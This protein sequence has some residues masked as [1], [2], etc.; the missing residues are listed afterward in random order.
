MHTRFA[1]RWT[2]AAVERHSAG[3]LQIGA[4][5]GTLAGPV[6]LEN[7]TIKTAAFDAH[8][9]HL[10]VNWLPLALLANRLAITRL[11]ATQV[12]LVVHRTGNDKPFRLTRPVVPHLP[13]IVAIGNIDV[14]DMKVFAPAL[15]QPV[16]ITQ[17]NTTLH[18][19][20][21][22]W[23][24]PAL[25]LKGPYI[26]ASGHGKWKFRNGEQ[27]DSSL[28]WNLN[29]PGQVPVGGRASLTGDEQQMAID[30]RLRK[31]ARA[32]LAAEVHRPFGNNPDW[33]G[34]LALTQLNARD[35]A[36]GLPEMA[37]TGSA[38]FSGTPDATNFAGDVYAH[39]PNSGEWHGKFAARYRTGSVDIHQLDLVR[40]NTPTQF[41]LAG[42]IGFVD[43]MPVPDLHGKWQAL[44]LP[45]T[46]RPWFE[47]PRGTL[48]VQAHNE[49]LVVNLSGDLSRGGTINAQGELK[50]RSPERKWNL[51]AAARNFRLSPAEIRAAVPAFNWTLHA[52]GD[53]Q[54]TRIDDLA[55]KGFGG[56]VN[57]NG[58]YAH[59]GMHR[60]HATVTARHLDPGLLF[61]EYPGRINLIAELSG[62]R[63]PSLTCAVL[64]KSLQG[65]LRNAPV[66]ATG[67][68][69]CSSGKW[70]FRNVNIRV[71]GNQLRFDGHLRRK[72][73]INWNL[74]A[75]ELSAVWPGLSGSLTSR[76][77][78]ELAGKTPLARFSLHAADLRYGDY[79]VGAAD[80]NVAMN[81]ATQGGDA[82]LEA[83]YMTF[84]GADISDLTVRAHGSLAAHSISLALKSPAGV[85]EIG[86]DGAL[87]NDTWRG[88]LQQIS[89]QPS[90]AGTWRATDIWHLRIG[91]AG[92][93]LPDACLVQDTARSCITTTWQRQHW[94]VGA[95]LNAVPLHDL[96]ALLP[97]GLEYSGNFAGTL[98]AS[99]GGTQQHLIDLSA[100]LSPGSIRNVIRHQQ[101]TLLDYTHG[102]AHIRM[103]ATHTNGT[104]HWALQDG[105]FLNLDTHI[106]R[107]PTPALKGR[108][109]GE[110]HDFALIPALIPDVSGLEG[111]LQIDLALGGTA[112]NPTFDGT[113]S[114]EEGA[115]KVP[116]LGLNVSD[117]MLNLQGNGHRLALNGTANSASGT[118]KW[119][120]I[121]QKRNGVWHA[122]GHLDG[123]EF[124]AADIPEAQV[125]ISP[126]LEFK[127]DGRDINLD[128]SVTIPYA[129]LRPRNLSN[130]AQVSQDQVIVGQNQ[131]TASDRW[132]IHARVLAKMGDQVTIKGFG[133]S[134]RITGSVQLVDEPGHFTT[135]NGELQIVD[136]LYTAYGQNLNIDRGRLMFNGGP[137]SNPALDIRALR[138]PAHPETVLPGQSEQQVGVVVRGSLRNP[139]VSLFSDPPLP[140][141]SLLAYLLTGQLPATASQSPLL[142]QPATDTGDAIA[143]SSG[144]FLAQQVGSQIGLS[145]VS[146][147]NV[148]T[149]VGTSTPSLFIGKYL[150]PRLY[151]SYGAGILQSI[152]TIRIRYTLGA[153]WMLE[154]E[155][156]AANSAD[157]IY[158]L[159]H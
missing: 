110:L 15:V 105:G 23:R 148:S 39:D 84:D 104:L 126:A 6:E 50:L 98:Q 20:N 45:L 2:L 36:N 34:T 61:P 93:S 44:S 65:T 106:D 26:A 41:N 81:N 91:A 12:D 124:R 88:N 143:Y 42:S 157:L 134:G 11:T 63:N 135:G 133:L 43:G 85:A 117:V 71:A 83:H 24:M 59:T 107:G 1:L 114:L 149:G 29:L 127:L 101:V 14:Q 147:Q 137:V 141:S 77:S 37:L 66:S 33:R 138:K 56:Q 76:G 122:E 53:E 125:N 131:A 18:L 78:V 80:A 67:G 19:D 99:G 95:T 46:G 51:V 156:G 154:A 25:S 113:A 60:W 96:Q 55:I 145:D 103:D 9:Q 116:R 159:E 8:I 10:N 27:L 5:D 22:E 75:P 153:R 47:S 142:G 109:Q 79:S 121:A 17:L 21:A 120:S 102:D 70:Q 64:L 89:L 28:D 151:V 129:K 136:G 132:K 30:V 52:G 87:E 73:Q 158:T 115:I 100:T 150:S 139:R 119:D 82:T 140:Q 40:N 74:D 94:Q 128:G 146:I 4:A 62:S 90:G 130:T 32:S 57:L 68:A 152:N 7:V 3:A 49:N 155:S 13:V 92:L 48:T 108:I 97:P 118:L 86:G 38:R 35:I 123:T 69:Q 144:E 111:K 72:T 58:G 54:Q 16:Q 31:P 112:G